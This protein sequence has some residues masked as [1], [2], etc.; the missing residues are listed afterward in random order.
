MA[1]RE[2]IRQLTKQQQAM[3]DRRRQEMNRTYRAAGSR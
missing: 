3:D 1:I 2:R